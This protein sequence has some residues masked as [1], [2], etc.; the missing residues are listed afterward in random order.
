MDKYLEIIPNFHTRI[1]FKLTLTNCENAYIINNICLIMGPHL[2]YT[3]LQNFSQNL[4]LFGFRLISTNFGSL[5][6]NPKSVFGY[7]VRILQ[8]CQFCVFRL[9]NQIFE[10]LAIFFLK[11]NNIFLKTIKL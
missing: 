4:P 3:G 8:C 6:P 9:E 10:N 11:I 2:Y 7:V 5:T 1:T